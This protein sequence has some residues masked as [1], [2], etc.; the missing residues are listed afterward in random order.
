MA[1]DQ[2]PDLWAILNSSDESAVWLVLNDNTWR[3]SL[4]H[5][6]RKRERRPQV[7]AR[8]RTLISR[9]LS[10]PLAWKPRTEITAHA[11]KRS[12]EI[13]AWLRAN[14]TPY[15]KYWPR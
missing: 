1:E 2:L 3:A 7:S 10:G 8:E 12:R 13:I 9:I 6:A 4:Q 5:H 15:Q 14:W 11:Q